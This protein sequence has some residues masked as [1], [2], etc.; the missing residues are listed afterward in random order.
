MKKILNLFMFSRS[1]KNTM[2]KL[3]S[4]FTLIEL[5]VVIA[6]I[7]ILSSVVIAG[8]TNARIKSRDTTRKQHIDQLVKATGLYFN[9]VGDVPGATNDCVVVTN[10]AFM[11]FLIPTYIKEIQTDPTKSALGTSGNYV[12]Q[13]QADR[14]GKYRYCASLENASSGNTD[15]AISV[16]GGAAVYNYCVTQ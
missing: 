9:Q 11:A 7:A 12:Y 15:P 3:V 10:A 4:G 8:L 16:C 1:N 6:I 13:N 14:T 5:L 2:P